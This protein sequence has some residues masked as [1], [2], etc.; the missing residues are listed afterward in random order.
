M[1]NAVCKKYRFEPCVAYISHG[2]GG[3]A[4]LL[5]HDTAAFAAKE[6]KLTCALNGAVARATLTMHGQRTSIASVYV[7]VHPHLRKLFLERL[8][9]CG[10]ISTD[11]IVGGDWNCVP[12]AS[13]DVHSLGNSAYPN[14]GAAALEKVLTHQGLTDLYRLVHGRNRSYSR[15][16]ATVNTRLDRIYARR[17]NSQWRW[18]QV[19]HDATMFRTEWASDHFPVVATFETVTARV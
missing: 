2:T 11:T 4:V 10:C 7:P 16:G 12:D 5:S 18:T 13:I 6:A 9:K 19:E 1:V 17:Y 14:I 15:H 8:G 3:A